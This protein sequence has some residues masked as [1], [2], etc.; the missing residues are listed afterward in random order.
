MSE[1]QELIKEEYSMSKRLKI[2]NRSRYIIIVKNK[3]HLKDNDVYVPIYRDGK[4]VYIV[5]Y[6]HRKRDELQKLTKF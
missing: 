3:K 2:L 4:K 1:R 6:D 5:S